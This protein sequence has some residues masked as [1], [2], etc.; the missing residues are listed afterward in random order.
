MSENDFALIRII[1]RL[2]KHLRTV[3]LGDKTER[4]VTNNNVAY[5]LS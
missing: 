2:L 5:N 3:F 1:F 4:F